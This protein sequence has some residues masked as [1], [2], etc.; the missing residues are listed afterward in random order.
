MLIVKVKCE[1]SCRLLVAYGS[2]RD[3]AKLYFCSKCVWCYSLT[4]DVSGPS[5]ISWLGTAPAPYGDMPGAGN[6]GLFHRALLTKAQMS[7]TAWHSWKCPLLEGPHL[8]NE[9]MKVLSN[10]VMCMCVCAI[11]GVT[12]GKCE[13][14]VLFLEQ[15]N[16]RVV[17]LP[18]NHCLNWVK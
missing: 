1:G 11:D 5:G 15:L 4:I 7:V 6:C 3:V 13:G 14:L 2:D 16:C 18:A 17:W 10:E 12:P 9:I 8:G